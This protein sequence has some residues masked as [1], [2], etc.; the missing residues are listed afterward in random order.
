MNAVVFSVT[1]SSSLSLAIG[2]E[3]PL[4]VYTKVE[5]N[6]PGIYL[7]YLN[8]TLKSCPST[9]LAQINT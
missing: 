1:S 5:Q 7:I 9:D 6:I 8:K 2:G 4:S 3:H